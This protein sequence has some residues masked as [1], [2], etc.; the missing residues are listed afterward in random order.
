MDTGLRR[1]WTNLGTGGR[2]GL[3]VGA[4][5]VVGVGGLMAVQA[6]SRPDPDRQSDRGGLSVALVTPPEPELVSGEVMEVGDLVDG[7]EHQEPPVMEPVLDAAYVEYDPAWSE[8]VE[9]D[10]EPTPEAR[11][12]AP[13]RRQVATTSSQG[14]RFG[15]DEPQ[16]DYVAERRARQERMDAADRNPP[17][18]RADSRVMR[19]DS[20]FQ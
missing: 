12:Q 6:Q 1:F 17:G 18:T 2:I 20:Y 5:A 19:S 11:Y 14:S 8:P 16:P 13:P 15:F 10:Y 9:A 3:V 7:Y 4:A